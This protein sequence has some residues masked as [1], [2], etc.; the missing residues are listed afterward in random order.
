MKRGALVLIVLLLVSCAEKLIEKP[1]NLISE[2]KMADV[3]YDMS[4]LIAAKNTS[5]TLLQEKGIDIMDYLYNKYDIDSV[6]FV[7]SDLY[8]AANTVVYE[9]LYEKV[10]TRLSKEKKEMEN[11]RDQKNDSISEVNKKKV[12]AQKKKLNEI[13]D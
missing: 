9:A 6:Q 8:Y 11:A 12:A 13:K 7:E 2:D 10:K 4:I 1:E 5:K 3:L